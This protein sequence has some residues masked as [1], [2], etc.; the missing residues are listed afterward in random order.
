MCGSAPARVFSENLNVPPAAPSAFDL[1]LQ[2]Q[3]SGVLIIGVDPLS[4]VDQVGQKCLLVC[5]DSLPS[6]LQVCFF[7]IKKIFDKLVYSFQIVRLMLSQKQAIK[8]VRVQ[9]QTQTKTKQKAD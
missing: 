8:F 4:L 1:I 6:S 2:K 3:G 7:F 5:C 9:A